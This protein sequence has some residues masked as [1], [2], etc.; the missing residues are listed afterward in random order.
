[1]KVVDIYE[2]AYYEDRA[3]VT[4]EVLEIL[5]ETS[6]LRWR[7]VRLK[8]SPRTYH[9]VGNE[10]QW[11]VRTFAARVVKLWTRRCRSCRCTD[12]RA[13]DGGCSWAEIDLC[14]E[15][16][17]EAKAEREKFEFPLTERARR[18]SVATRAG[19]SPRR[20]SA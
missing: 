1:L 4:F 15:C 3:G 11:P 5:P 13:C 9:R 17:T 7:V 6:M 16:T 19:R 8:G 14:S 12:E 18:C 2:G 10:G 20:R